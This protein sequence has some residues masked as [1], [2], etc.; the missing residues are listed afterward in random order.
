MR[1]RILSDEDEFGVTIGSRPSLFF[2]PL[3]FSWK[4]YLHK[5]KVKYE[6]RFRVQI[7]GLGRKIVK[8]WQN[9]I[10]IVSIPSTALFKRCECNF[11]R[12]ISSSLVEWHWLRVHQTNV[13]YRNQGKQIHILDWKF[14]PQ[15]IKLSGKRSEKKLHLNLL[16]IYLHPRKRSF[17]IF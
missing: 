11:L 16:T 12:N 15:M 5:Y 7:H 6:C 4:R 14:V 13:L 10:A 3:S 8:K 9:S 17:A 1:S 2:K